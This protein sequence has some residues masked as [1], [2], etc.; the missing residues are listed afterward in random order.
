MKKAVGSARNSSSYSRALTGP[1]ISLYAPN[2][3]VLYVYP[4]FITQVF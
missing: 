1:T 4:N 3:S 2:R